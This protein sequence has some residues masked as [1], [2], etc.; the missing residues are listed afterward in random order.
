MI[1]NDFSLGLKWLWSFR[2]KKYIFL[3]NAFNSKYYTIILHMS[4]IRERGGGII[5][6]EFHDK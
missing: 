4:K 1:N 2:F 5:F 3:K 6:E